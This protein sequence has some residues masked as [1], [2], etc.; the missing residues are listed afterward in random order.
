[1]FHFQRSKA[2]RL[3]NVSSSRADWKPSETARQM[4]AIRL[5]GH[6]QHKPLGWPQAQG[7]RINKEEG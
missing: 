6:D 4:A 3:G 7:S 2:R 5:A 1:M